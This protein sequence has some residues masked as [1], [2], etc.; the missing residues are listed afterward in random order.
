MSSPSIAPQ[1]TAVLV[2]FARQIELPEFTL[3]DAGHA[4]LRVS[5]GLDLEFAADGG[6]LTLSADLGLLP[7][8]CAMERRVLQHNVWNGTPERGWLGLE[9]DSGHLHLFLREPAPG[10]DFLTFEEH[11][12]SFLEQAAEW[13]AVLLCAPQIAHSA[14]PGGAPVLHDPSSRA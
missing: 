9:H 12:R 1:V 11:L 5:D 6:G 13:R 10:L 4:R 14:T 7:Q 2:E 3:D 8:D